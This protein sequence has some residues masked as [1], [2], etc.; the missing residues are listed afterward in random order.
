MLI[1]NTI[2]QKEIDIFTKAKYDFN[3]PDEMLRDSCTSENAKSIVFNNEL[4]GFIIENTGYIDVLYIL[5][6]FRKQGIGRLIIEQLKI[7]NDVIYAHPFTNESEA[8]FIKLGFKVDE[9]Y[10]PSDTNTVVFVKEEAF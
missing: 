2:S 1:M 4:V 6:Q 3:D 10:D 8:F 9:D 5:P 7:N